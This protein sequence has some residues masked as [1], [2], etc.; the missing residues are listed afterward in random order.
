MQR[1]EALGQL[2]SSIEKLTFKKITCPVI[3]IIVVD[4]DPQ[5]TSQEFVSTLQKSYRWSIKYVCEKRR[6][7]PFARNTA[8]YNCS[9]N[10]DY[11][12]FIDDDE[13]VE[14]LWLEEL[15]IAQKEYNADV[16]T[17]PVIPKFT[18]APPRWIE[19]G[20]FFARTRHVSG[21]D[22]KHVA[23]NNV[24][25]SK[26]V[27][28][29]MK[30]TQLFNEKMSLT[31]GTDNHFFLRVYKKGFKMIW[32]NEAVVYEWVPVSRANVK[33]ILKRAY[34]IGITDTICEREIFPSKL[35][36][37]KQL[38]RGMGRVV[39]G[40]ILAIPSLAFGKHKLIRV[41]R[42][43]SRGL[44]FI[45]ATFGFKYDEYKKIHKV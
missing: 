4:N 36:N 33:W 43:V 21:T 27:I 13:Y 25:I 14:A 8:I 7:I 15:L 45:M 40:T 3:E 22:M 38:V 41:L 34:R 11:I 39:L 28:D 2:L 30:Q 23:T 9:D 24:L 6:G 37:I 16:V 29:Y 35:F 18:K 19:E 31:G 32:A 10:F 20:N 42:G 17:G 44:G 12:V 5:A 26:D 1:Q